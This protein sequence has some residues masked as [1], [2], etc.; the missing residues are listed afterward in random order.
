MRKLL[1]LALALLLLLAACGNAAPAQS[2][3]PTPTPTATATPT[4]T[5]SAVPTLGFSKEDYISAIDNHCTNKG[6]T[7]IGSG[8]QS[9][10]D[11]DSTKTSFGYAPCQDF[12][13]FLE[14]NNAT[15]ELSNIS[16]QVDKR[17]ISYDNMKYFGFV[18]SMTIYEL[19]GDNAEKI[20]EALHLT[21]VS[22]DAVN[23]AFSTYFSYSYIIDGDS[24]ALIIS[25]QQ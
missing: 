18:S 12:F 2:P 19:E 1:P 3:S 25:P 7:T 22:S 8:E 20:I 11:S 5:P 9:V 6:F 14:E 16:M 15:K 4:P 10:V 17:K 24:V 21:E 13:L 23:S